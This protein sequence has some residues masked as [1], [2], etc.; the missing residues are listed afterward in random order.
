MNDPLEPK[1][2]LASNLTKHA[3]VP[4]KIGQN[5]KLMEIFDINDASL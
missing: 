3:E 1:N 5:E 2:G 4:N